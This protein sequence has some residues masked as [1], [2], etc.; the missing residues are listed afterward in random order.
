MG[1]QLKVYGPGEFGPGVAVT[2][3][4]PWVQ[5]SG[6]AV[7][8]TIPFALVSHVVSRVIEPMLVLHAEADKKYPVVP[9]GTTG[10]FNTPLL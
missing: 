8:V 1:V 6:S 7:A 9:G 5:T 4:I 3:P 10:T 2:D